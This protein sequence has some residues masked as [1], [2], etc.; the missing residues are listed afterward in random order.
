[1]SVIGAAFFEEMGKEFMDLLRCEASVDPV[2]D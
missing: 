1:L 2:S